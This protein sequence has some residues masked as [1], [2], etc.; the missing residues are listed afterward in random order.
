MRPA[1]HLDTSI[2]DAIVEVDI[3]ASS[4]RIFSA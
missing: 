4:G 3:A 1:Y 2:R